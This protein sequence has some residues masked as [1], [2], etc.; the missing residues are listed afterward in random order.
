MR[1]VRE[2]K[3]LKVNHLTSES[4]RVKP[5]TR[6]HVIIIGDP[7]RIIIQEL[8]RARKCEFR[9]QSRGPRMSSMSAQP[10]SNVAWFSG[11]RSRARRTVAGYTEP[12]SG[13]RMPEV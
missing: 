7:A 6:P 4:G 11:S 2:G 5:Q 12:A 1:R 9:A 13:C 10:F 3:M 8:E